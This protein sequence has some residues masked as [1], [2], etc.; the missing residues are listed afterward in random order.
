MNE[1]ILEY[2]KKPEGWHNERKNGIWASMLPAILGMSVYKDNTAEN[3]YDQLISSETPVDEIEGTLARG[4][5]VEVVV[6]EY[7]YPELT[8]T[9]IKYFASG[10][11]CPTHD[12][13]HAH[14]D[15]VIVESDGVP[16]TWECKSYSRYTIDKIRTEGLHNDTII[17]MHGQMLALNG[18][19]YGYATV[20]NS[21]PNEWCCLRNTTDGK[22]HII[23]RKNQELCDMI[24]DY[25]ERFWKAV[26]NRTRPSFKVPTVKIEKSGTGIIGRLEGSEWSEKAVRYLEINKEISALDKEKAAI[27]DELKSLTKG[28]YDEVRFDG[29]QY[30]KYVKSVS[31]GKLDEKLLKAK[32]PDLNLDGCYTEDS[33]STTFRLYAANQPSGGEATKTTLEVK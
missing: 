31:K 24:L 4:K 29:G 13:L 11:T 14:L 12:Y 18:K 10:F 23:V 33:I 8:G 28:K 30:I 21:D 15:G 25:S 19:D 3:L 5:H 6:R 1:G 32:F 7:I 22:P 26:Q 2:F 17:Q 27:A 20:F 16:A 9:Q